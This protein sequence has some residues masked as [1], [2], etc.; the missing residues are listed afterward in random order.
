MTPFFYFFGKGPERQISTSSRTEIAPGVFAQETKELRRVVCVI[1]PDEKRTLT[2][3][4][5]SKTVHPGVENQTT[6]I[7]PGEAPAK[8]E[9]KNSGGRSTNGIILFKAEP[10]T[11]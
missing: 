2:I 3:T 7:F 6:R 9:V 8:I 4:N 1:T 5:A 11:P 10:A